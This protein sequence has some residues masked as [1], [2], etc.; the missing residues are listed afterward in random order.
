MNEPGFVFE[1]VTVIGVGLIG[2]SFA[3]ALK[4]HGLTR[5]I[6][7]CGRQVAELEKAVELGVID[8]FDTR[9]AQAVAGAELIMICVPLGAFQ[10]VFEAIRDH[11]AED[12]IISDV[13]SAKGSVVEAAEAVWQNLPAGLVP[14]HPI[15]GTEKS[16][17][18]HSFAELYQDRC[19][20]LTPL[21]SSAPWAVEKL[22]RVWEAVGSNVVCMST[23][24]HDEV[25]GATSHLP[26]ML[27]FALVDSLARMHE[28]SEIFRFA[29]GGFRD[30]TRIAS[31]DPVMWRDICVANHKAIAGLLERFQQELAELTTDIRNRDGEA[32]EAIFKRAK[33]ARDTHVIG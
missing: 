28:H 24:H 11:V 5:R 18:E 27:A 13:G 22:T 1:H 31:S 3:R 20:I 33:L 2:G 14:G 6:T 7:G 12:A 4:K 25:L 8:D 30:F 23:E 9:P 32:L 10:S 17:V 15:A 21:Q 19:L 16:G 26:H 29:A